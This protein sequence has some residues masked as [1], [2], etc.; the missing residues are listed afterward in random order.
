MPLANNALLAYTRPSRPS[1]ARIGIPDEIDELA[2]Q[3]RE[4][5]QARFE[6]PGLGTSSSTL[7]VAVS[8]TQRVMLPAPMMFFGVASSDSTNDL[9]HVGARFDEEAA[10]RGAYVRELDILG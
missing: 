10:G 3:L 7:S 4:Q 5:R 8:D 9:L 2:I 1:L 6:Q